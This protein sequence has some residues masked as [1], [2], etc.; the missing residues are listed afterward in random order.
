MKSQKSLQRAAIL[1]CCCMLLMTNAWAQVKIVAGPMNGYSDFMEA[2]IWVQT[3]QKAS[4]QIKYW[5]VD[6]MNEAKTV[7]A[8]LT[9]AQNAFCTTF[10]IMHL[11][12]G[13]KFNYQVLLDGKVQKLSFQPQFVTQPL[14]QYRTD[15]PTIRFAMGSCFYAPDAAH[16]RPGKPYGDST[17]I[18]EHIAAQKPDF[19]LWLGDNIYLREPDWGSR[20]GFLYRYSKARATP[21]LQ[22]LLGIA[23]HYAIW[24]DHDFGPNDADRSFY[25]KDMAAD[26]FK[27]FWPNPNFDVFG[28]GGVAGTFTWGDCQFFL[29]DNRYFRAPNNLKDHAKDYLGKDQL[30]WLL[31]ALTFSKATFKF[32]VNGG[33]VINPAGVYEN[34]AA[35]PAERQYLLSKIEEL[36]IPGVFF[37]S[38]DR[39]HTVLSKMERP[40]TYPLYDLTCSPLTSGPYGMN[41]ANYFADPATLYV[42]R[43]Y[44]MAEITG[45]QK[46]RTLKFTIYN[47]QGK[48]IWT[49]QIKSSELK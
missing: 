12:P 41:E 10:K 39:H 2:A 42:G 48:E 44:A 4:V 13:K 34:Y 5:P 33:Q 15:P 25:N 14:W 40:N 27:L 21:E 46:E 23:H 38:G 29:L 7:P 22:P 49:R 1:F 32:I 16:D 37:F 17:M 3:N 35:Y 18:F 11:E 24:D 9:D 19:M 36:K 28:K 6:K 31:E 43:N 47:A 8:Q 45:P 26:M 20:S 30:Q